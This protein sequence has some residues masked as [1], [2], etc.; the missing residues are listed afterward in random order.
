MYGQDGSGAATL[1]YGD[2]TYEVIGPGSYV[3]CAVSGRRIL[4]EDLRYWSVDRQEAYASPRQ[5]L[6]RHEEIRA[7][8]G[9]SS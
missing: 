4:L 6:Q 1:R 5:A 3:V 2:G 9:G 7:A 8:S